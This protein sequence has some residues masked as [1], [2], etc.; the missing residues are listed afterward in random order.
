MELKDLCVGIGLQDEMQTAVL[1]FAASHTREQYAELL[2]QLKQEDTEKSAREELKQVLGEDPRQEKMLTCML[3]CA[4]DAYRWYQKNRVSD[5][6]YFATMKCFSR[7]ISECRE[8]TGT[9]AFDR[10]WWTPRQIG[11]RLFRIGELEYELSAYEGKPAISMHI[12]SDADLSPDACRESFALA[13]KFFA[14]VLPEWSSCEWYCESWLL[15]PRLKEWLPEKSNILQFQHLFE[16][17]E[18][19]PENRDAILWVFQRSLYR[20]PDLTTLPERTSLQRKMKAA[21]LN[22]ESTGAATGVLK[23]EY[24]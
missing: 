13:G 8:K 11:C 16:I 15:S 23:M 18:T 14:D 24:R 4:L 5:E 1:A 19:D 20:D 21:L 6:I 3:W 12:P 7:F 2:E 22:G 9:Y 17:H 10:A